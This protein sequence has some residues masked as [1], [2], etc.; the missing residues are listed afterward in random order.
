MSLLEFLKRTQDT[1]LRKTIEEL[2]QKMANPLHQSPVPPHGRYAAEDFRR[3]YEA[4]QQRI[5]TAPGA[6]NYTGS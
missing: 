6:E 5:V 2:A 1:F 4:V 3:E